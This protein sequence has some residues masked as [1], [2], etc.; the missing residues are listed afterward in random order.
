MM[1]RRLF[2]LI[3]LLLA[4]TE[5]RPRAEGQPPQP[6]LPLEFTGRLTPVQRVSVSSSVSG[7]VVDLPVKEG[8]QVKKGDIL[9]RLDATRQAA[10]WRLA[11][12]RLAAVQA[13]LAELKTPARAEEKALT[14]A[15]LAEAEATLKL[16][17]AE[18]LRLRRLRMMNA[19]SAEDV[20]KAEA[21]LGVARARVE[22]QRAAA[23]TLIAGASPERIKTTQ[24]EVAVAQ[25]ERDRA[26]LLF[27]AT[28]I[29]AP[30]DGTVLKLSVG[31]GSVTNPDA[32]GLV[33]TA[34]L[35]ELGDLSALEVEVEVHE[36]NLVRFFKGQ[37]CEMRPDASPGTLYRGSVDRLSPTV[38]RDR[39]TCTVWVKLELP[40]KE[41]TL[42]V[43]A[44]ATVR[45][46]PR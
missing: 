21:S 35:C 33:R 24:A 25:A 43:D 7:Q 42:P 22:K 40:K 6:S 1:L 11:E 15:E 31:V 3:L 12:A 45:F 39:N 27:E 26:R 18:I 9:A 23:N 28:V 10:D 34:S 32:F 30:I 19:A 44:S 41:H 20:Q 38:D 16:A 17:E 5:T 2:L 4:G 36:R 29:R 37:R 14:R 8:Q 46:L 13:R